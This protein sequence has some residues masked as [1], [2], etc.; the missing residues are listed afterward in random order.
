M[1]P[2]R[3]LD[4]GYRMTLNSGPILSAINDFM[5][6]VIEVGSPWVMPSL[7]RKASGSGRIPTVGFY[8]TDYPESYIRP[9]AEKIFPPRTAG[10]MVGLAERHLLK[11]YSRMDGVFCAS[12]GLLTRLHGIGLRR[13]FHTPLGVD[14][15]LFTPEK[16]SLEFRER[17]GAGGTR[18][19]V[20][21]LARLHREKGIDLLMEA[22][23]SFR[24]PSSIVL[25]IAGHGP[26]E[27]RVAEFIAR[28]PEVRRVG[29]LEDREAAAEAMASADVYLSLGP[30]ETFGLAGLEAV[31]SGTVTVFPDAGAGAEMAE[32]AGVLPPFSMAD[33]SEALTARILEAVNLDRGAVSPVLRARVLAGMDWHTV[34]SREER[35]YRRILE[36]RAADDPE[37]LIP[38]CMWWEG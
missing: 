31:A 21:F 28:F 17:L 26:A 11:T 23:P 24:D 18:K 10:V 8:H 29:Y 4:S 25:A 22:Y 16:R 12:R 19:L 1:T 37:S 20:L 2:F 13:L 30:V 3:L 6:D 34:F 5:P 33:G 14:P 27:G 35:F 9:L 38:P 15:Q 36:A 7:V 32:L